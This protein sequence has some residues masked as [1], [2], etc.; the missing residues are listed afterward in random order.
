V[1][2][3]IRLELHSGARS[4]AIELAG[5]VDQVHPGHVDQAAANGDAWALD[6]WGELAPMLGVALSNAVCVLNP[7][8][9]V[10]GG[11]MLGRT[12]VLRE[13]VIASLLVAAPAA[14]TERLEILDAVLGDDAGLVGAALLAARD[15]STIAPDGAS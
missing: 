14:L 9:L 10:L 8:R 2:A 1:Q 5:G 12:P 11:G 6:L 4:S 15:V 7:A 13:Q 3:R